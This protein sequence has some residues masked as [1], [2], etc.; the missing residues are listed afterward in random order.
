MSIWPYFQY[1]TAKPLLTAITDAS[2]NRTLIARSQLDNTTVIQKA[3]G[4]TMFCES[5]RQFGSR[6]N[7]AC[8]FKRLA[9]RKAFVFRMPELYFSFA[10]FPTKPDFFIKAL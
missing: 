1:A 5:I 7:N 9:S 8:C 6:L 4:L 3:P 2:R 10:R